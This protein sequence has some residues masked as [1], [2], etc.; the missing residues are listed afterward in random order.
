MTALTDLVDFIAPNYATD[1]S[2]RDA[3][4]TMAT[5]YLGATSALWGAVYND[6]IA[7]LAAHLLTVYDPNGPF[8]SGGGGS[9]SGSVTGMSTGDWSVSF[10]GGGGAGAGGAMGDEG[11]ERTSYGLEYLRLRN[12]RAAG[13]AR[14]VR[15]NSTD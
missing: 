13:R 7:N 15:P 8:S 3:A 9:V 5:R 2:R 6:A 1:T 12:S 11:L 10:G 4:I 14:V